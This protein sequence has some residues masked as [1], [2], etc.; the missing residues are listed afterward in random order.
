M[1]AHSLSLAHSKLPTIS[2]NE[3]NTRHN[4]FQATKSAN[5]QHT[6]EHPKLRNFH[7]IH[8]LKI[9]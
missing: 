5:I 8:Y 1:Y 6:I 4:N 7:L 2:I 9:F 3:S